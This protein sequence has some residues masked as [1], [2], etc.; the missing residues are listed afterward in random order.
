MAHADNI[1][2]VVTGRFANTGDVGGH[3]GYTH[4]RKLGSLMQAAARQR[5]QAG[6]SKQICKKCAHWG[7]C[8]QE[9]L[10]E[11]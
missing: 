11:K 1:A 4:R 6:S 7:T 8:E 3:Q 2:E 10:K 9:R 5:R